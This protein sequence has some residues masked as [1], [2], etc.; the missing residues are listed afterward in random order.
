MPMVHVRIM[1]VLVAHR[2]VPV[3]VRMRFGDRAVVGVGVMFVVDMGVFVLQ[4][5]V[6]VFVVVALGQV[7]PEAE[8]HQQ[9]G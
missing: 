1:R 2:F 7:Q 9:A 5:L 6:A 8:G 4:R 3:P